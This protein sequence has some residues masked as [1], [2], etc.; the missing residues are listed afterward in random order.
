MTA[1]FAAACWFIANIVL[2][3]ALR[4]RDAYVERVIVSFPGAWVVVGLPLT[5]SFGASAMLFV[6]ALFFS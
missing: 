5:L 6:R 1:V 3:W 4:P 2:F